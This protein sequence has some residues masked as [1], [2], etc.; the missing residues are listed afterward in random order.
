MSNEKTSVP[1]FYRGDNWNPE[2]SIG[3]LLRTTVSTLM[4]AA[5]AAMRPYGLT[6]V[7]WAPLMIISRGG[8]PTAASLARDLNT[9]TGAMTRMLDRLEAKGLLQRTRSATDRRVVELSLTEQGRELTTKIPH[10]LAAV[11]NK[12][13]SGFSPE[14]FNT[15][16]QLLR[17]IIAN[18]DTSI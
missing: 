9:D 5:E 7:Q 2:E 14:E 15:L 13:L 18:R 17:R 10:H 1:D 4:R 8:N 3:Y 12:H 6:S 16:K 11:Y